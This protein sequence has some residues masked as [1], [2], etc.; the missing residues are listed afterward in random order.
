MGNPNY[1][2]EEVSEA[3]AKL[4]VQPLENTNGTDDDGNPTGGNVRGKGVKIDWQNGPRGKNA[5]GKLADSNG[6]FVEDVIYAAK[7]RLEFFQNSKYS[8]DANARAITHLD[9]ALRALNSRRQERAERGVEG[10]HEV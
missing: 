3:Y 7:Q 6:A 4:N 8:H 9:E 10:Q 5:N 1:K 2:T